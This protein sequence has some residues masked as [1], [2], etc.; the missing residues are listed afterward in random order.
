MRSMKL[1]GLQKLT[2]LD[3]PEKIACTVFV[4]G[5]NL[6]CP[7]CQNSALL[8]GSE[9]PDAMD[10]EWFLAFLRR[11]RG[12]LDGVCI[13]GGEPLL[14]PETAELARAVKALGFLVKLDT[15]GC[16]PDRLEQ[17]MAEGLADYVAMDLKNAPLRYAETVGLPQL[18]LRP[19]ER[20]VELLLSGRVAYEFRTTVVRELHT[21][22]AFSDIGAWIRGAE[23]YYLQSYVESESVLRPG[24]TACAPEELEAY[25][26]IV[27]PF[28]RFA[29]VRGI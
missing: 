3:Y 10:P 20:S 13:S 21:A 29:A 11:R 25:C 16:F 23:R 22:Q 19:V 28:V 17:W 1:M 5:C 18:D 4:G 15:N 7:F 12:I 26:A 8:D 14:H 9:T 27:R 2:L 6:R 24:L